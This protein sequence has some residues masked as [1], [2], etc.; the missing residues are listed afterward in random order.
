MSGA[1]RIENFWYQDSWLRWVFWPI[2]SVLFLITILKRFLYQAD[3]LSSK[4][5]EVPVVVVG[6]I[7]VGGTGKTPFIGFI[8]KQLIERGLKVGI[9]SRGYLSH[10]PTYPHMV[11]KDDTVQ[12]IGDEVFMLYRQLDIP[13]AIDANRGNAAALLSKYHKLDVIISDDGLQHY[14]MARDF[15]ILLVDQTRAFGN[16]LCIPFGPL[17]ERLSRINSVDWVVQNGDQNK[18]FVKPIDKIER[19][20]SKMSIEPIELVNIQT[21][22]LMPLSLINGNAVN[23]VCGIGNPNRFFTSLEP[24]CGEI[25]KICFRRSPRLRSRRF[26]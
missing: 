15:E 1:S 20:R 2:S 24:L 22:E 5:A 21:K 9:V 11:K 6:N 25:K 4:K 10:A 17:R 3:I 26:F 8:A 19:T 18:A 16:R 7:T 12:C 14:K 13:I 23:G